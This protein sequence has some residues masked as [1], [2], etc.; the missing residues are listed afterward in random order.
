MR[1]VI[2]LQC[3]RS[4][5]DLA[6]AMLRQRGPH[7]V[8]VL[9][10]A[11]DRALIAAAR[12]K[13][14]GLIADDAIRIWD[15]PGDPGTGDPRMHAI[16]RETVI[17]TLEA[18]VLVS[19]RIGAGEPGVAVATGDAVP[20]RTCIVLGGSAARA[21][22]EHLIVPHREDFLRAD[23]IFVPDPESCSAVAGLL[24]GA[25]ETLRSLGAVPAADGAGEPGWTGPA[26][27]L[28]E[29]CSA[30]ATRSQAVNG[31]REDRPALALV[32]PFPPTRS[33][34]AE[35]A[36]QLL[37]PLSKYYR[38][39]LICDQD[40]VLD[41]R[42]GQDYP[43]RDPDWL[44]AHADRFD[45]VLYH[46]GNAPLHQYMYD[47]IAAVPGVV[48]LHD[49]FLMDG[50]CVDLPPQA[51][52][53]LIFRNHGIRGLY[54][55]SRIEPGS[56]AVWPLPGNLE[57]L[58]QA[59]GVIVH[60]EESF[61]L[62]EHWHGRAAAQ[63]W[64]RIPHLRPLAELDDARRLD[65]RKRLGFSRDDLVICSFGH[66]GPTKLNREIAS[67]LARS[68][69][70]GD[71]RVRLVF[72]GEAARQYG[73][74]I[75][76]LATELPAA[77]CE[78]TGWVDAEGY[79]D[80]LLAADIAVQLRSQ[81]RGETSGSVLDCLNYG[82]P[83]IVN[84]H[85]SMRDLEADAVLRIPDPVEESALVHALET[86]AQDGALRRRLA[87]RA[88]SVIAEMH[89]P[90][91]CAR[92]YYEA[93]ESSV[94][95]P[96]AAIARL[97][98]RLSELPMDRGGQLELA[99]ALAFDFPPAP[100]QPVLF[101]DVSAVA[102]ND[103]HTGIQRVIRSILKAF[104]L[105][106]DLPCEVVPVRLGPGGEYVTALRYAEKILGMPQGAVAED[107]V[108]VCRGD[109][110]LVLD[111]DF[112]QNVLRRKIFD[113]FRNAGAQ[114]WHVVYD[115]LPV[116]LP[117]Y[118]PEG[119]APRFA[120]WLDVVQ[121]Y[122]GAVCISQS[123][124]DELRDWMK[125]HGEPGKPLPRIGWFHLGADLENSVPTRG[126]PEDAGRV[127][128]ELDRRPTFLMVGTVEPRKGHA[129]TLSAFEQ[130]W[131]EGIDAN[132]AIVGKEGWKVKP[133]AERL[134]DH[135]ELGARL[136]WLSSISDEYLELIYRASACLIFASEGEGFGLPLIEAAQHGLPI[137]ARDLPVFIEVAG[138]HAVYFSGAE[139]QALAGAIRDW[140]VDRAAGKTIP[141]RGMPWLTWDR[142][143]QMLLEELGIG[144][145]TPAALRTR[146]S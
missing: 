2:E 77:S 95:S 108:D 132:L 48:V 65:A 32:S 1:I 10:H 17:R 57:V 136:F 131:A 85:G 127:L 27:C 39:H 66:I 90:D 6:S 42:I 74:S 86:L 13:L 141:S 94:R 112:G 58:Q 89:D 51:V 109:L 28:I 60:G 124:A 46:F 44:K 71:A 103:I 96:R 81:S 107:P 139:P 4:G 33:G 64:F 80:H 38:I 24:G 111:L 49:F 55:I 97:P 20:W 105:R 21:D 114:I 88:R 129:Q 82:I 99:K 102:L 134:R 54:E 135:D 118:F 26:Q 144:A 59:T 140:L 61:R 120:D 41:D 123:V 56:F 52:Q 115:L 70:A 106:A 117:Q 119:T 100:R 142:S 15:S 83:T 75:V 101:V 130:L 69:L 133:L 78:I 79:K 145:R 47:L 31:M 121:S 45:R 12:K 18:D 98:V 16:M 23:R 84:A 53:D 143:A 91:A 8:A 87:A 9:L 34:I 113:R 146:V 62:A 92:A 128:A 19:V 29:E 138:S 137:L 72:V 22:W 3:D 43:V 5:L 50:Q 37:Q 35:Y 63:G 25:A 104:L 36:T 73:E 68:R 67:A 7:E 11:A 40:R 14:R 110:F 30:I 93:V 116:R 125:E 76:D 122:D 126:L